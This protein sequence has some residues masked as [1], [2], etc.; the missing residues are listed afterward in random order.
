MSLIENDTDTFGCENGIETL[1]EGKYKYYTYKDIIL[2]KIILISITS[3]LKY[4]NQYIITELD[5]EKSMQ[6][7]DNMSAKNENEQVEHAAVKA[8]RYLSSV[9]LNTNISDIEGLEDLKQE[10]M[11]GIID[12]YAHILN[13]L[14]IC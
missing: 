12:I 13:V 2:T 8:T 1:T 10:K 14:Q 3:Y 7:S 6:S 5:N 4:N 11:E 9:T